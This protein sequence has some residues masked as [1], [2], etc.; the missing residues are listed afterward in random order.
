MIAVGGDGTLHE[1]GFSLLS[2]FMPY[3]F[4][5]QVDV[6]LNFFLMQCLEVEPLDVSLFVNLFYI[7]GVLLEISNFVILHIEI[8]RYS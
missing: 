3:D 8:C 1:V 7:H 4:S 6:A 5:L 2:N